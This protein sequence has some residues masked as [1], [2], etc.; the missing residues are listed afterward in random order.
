LPLARGLQSHMLRLRSHRE[1][2]RRVLGSGTQRPRLTGPTGRPGKADA[3][4][5]IT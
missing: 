1:G 3:N 4:D 2:A 5:R